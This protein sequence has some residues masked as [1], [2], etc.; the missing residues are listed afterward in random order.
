ME[1]IIPALAMQAAKTYLERYFESFAEASLDAL[2]SHALKALDASLQDDSISAK[3]CVL[4]F[5][6]PDLPFTILEDEA[7]APHVQGLQ[8][9]QTGVALKL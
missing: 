7:L 4:G 2:I 9:G 3:N 5:A 6:G 1:R 8:E